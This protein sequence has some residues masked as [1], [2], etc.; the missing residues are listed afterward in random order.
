MQPQIVFSVWNENGRV[1]DTNIQNNFESMDFSS[2]VD[3]KD[4][5]L[6]IKGLDQ[7]GA[8]IQYNRVSI[9]ESMEI[10]VKNENCACFNTLGFF[11]DKLD[12]LKE[13]PYFGPNDG[14][15]VKKEFYKKM[16]NKEKEGMDSVTEYLDSF[17]N[18]NTK[19]KNFCFIH[20]CHLKE[21]GLDVLNH[22]LDTI[23]KS[24]LLNEMEKIFVIHNDTFFS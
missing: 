21:S 12:E 3:I 14:L 19:N 9:E 11:K 8:D 4:Q 16:M 1:I 10:A 18:E 6:F 15:W 20:S 23:K 5:F 13:S 22:L 17:Q 7:I 24:G 2:V